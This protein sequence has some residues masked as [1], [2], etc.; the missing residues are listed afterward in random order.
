MA[1]DANGPAGALPHQPL[2][3]RDCLVV[4]EGECDPEYS[5]G[6]L[7]IEGQPGQS[8]AVVGVVLP[9][10][11]LTKAINVSV[12]CAYAEERDTQL[13]ETYVRTWLGFL[14]EEFVERVNFPERD[15]VFGHDPR[16]RA[17]VPFGEALYAVANDHFAF[18][19]AESGAGAFDGGDK[20][21]P[22][23]EARFSQIEAGIRAIQDALRS[24]GALPLSPGPPAPAT[25]AAPPGLDPGVVQQAR[26][27]GIDEAAGSGTRRSKGSALEKKESRGRGLNGILDQAEGIGSARSTGSAR[28][29][30]SALRSLQ[31]LLRSELY[32]TI[33]GFL[34]EDWAQ[35]AAARGVDNP[36]V[37]ARG[38]LEHRSRIQNYQT[39][40]RFAWMLGGIWDCLRQGRV[41]EARARA[42]L[43]VAAADQTA[44]D[45]GSWLLASKVLLEHAPP[46][47]VFGHHALPEGWEAQHSRL[48]D[49]RWVELY[50]HK[51]KDFAEFQ[52]KKFRLGKGRSYPTEDDNKEKWKPETK[53]TAKPAKG[54]KKG[55]EKNTERE[56]GASSS[57]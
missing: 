15:L 44:H 3:L 52:E 4:Q 25:P 36:A 18:V 1:S 7:Q 42:A 9:A 30:A 33:E 17:L 50:M 40:V 53:K 20:I 6:E 47:A 27:A 12:Q 39:T 55:K 48:L 57:A 32:Q 45:R 35:T 10:G 28:S 16:G 38:W 49:P 14:N 8:L 43:G 37:T 2:Q 46:F 21:A 34:L 5:I 41:D 54:D 51:L 19:T 22:E 23:L 31:G 11:S 26:A 13:D 24:P 29:K 56:P